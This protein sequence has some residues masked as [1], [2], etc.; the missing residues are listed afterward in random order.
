MTQSKIERLVCCCCGQVT[1]GRQW[2][3]RDTGFGLCGSCA[4]WIANKEPAEDMKSNY[5]VEGVNYFIA[6]KEATQP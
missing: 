4:V 2:Y 1:T 5:G 6:P 3:N